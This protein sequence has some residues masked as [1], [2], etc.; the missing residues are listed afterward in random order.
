MAEWFP[1]AVY[2]LCFAASATCALLLLRGYARS[3][4]R[5]LFWS[6]LCF[7]LLAANNFLVIIDMMVIERTDLRLHRTLLSLAAV[8]VLL[9]GLVWPREGR[10]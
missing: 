1:S 5:L 3:R 8:S 10:Q 7:V 4:A 9:F 2:L 6:G